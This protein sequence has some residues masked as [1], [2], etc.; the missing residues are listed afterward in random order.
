MHFIRC[1]C[2]AL[3]VIFC[4]PAYAEAPGEEWVKNG[5]VEFDTGDFYVP[6]GYSWSKASTDEQQILVGSKKEPFS[7][8]FI[9]IRRETWSK[10]R[11]QKEI[12]E[13]LKARPETE[14]F[15]IELA[16]PVEAPF[17]LAESHE[18]QITLL[19]QHISSAGTLTGTSYYGSNEHH[20]VML[21]CIGKNGPRIATDL[22]SSFKEKL[23]AQET[24]KT[25]SKLIDIMG[26]IAKF[27]YLAGVLVAAGL[28]TS[29][30]RAKRETIHNPYDAALT[31]IKWVVCLHIPLGVL[32][33][34]RQADATVL[35]AFGLLLSVLVHVL[36]FA[37]IP[38]YFRGS[39]EENH[40]FNR[41]PVDEIVEEIAEEPAPEFIIPGELVDDE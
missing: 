3:V 19:N 38:L 1:L 24:L 13:F 15:S 7:F 23:G 25:S 41:E 33:L 40:P 21:G 17:P 20:S 14:K 18:S 30:N 9:A 37:A 16:D 32:L 8:V 29:V 10:E 4:A 31:G 39:W 27:V 35:D 36:I 6:E 11:C 28:A 34:V 12:L 2:L 26:K 5:K 22:A